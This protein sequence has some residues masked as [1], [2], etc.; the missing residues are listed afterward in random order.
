MPTPQSSL[1][2]FKEVKRRGLQGSLSTEKK[3]LYDEAER[4]GMLGDSPQDLDVPRSQIFWPTNQPQSVQGL[5]AR[6][7]RQQRRDNLNAMRPSAGEN[8]MGMADAG[9]TFMTGAAGQTAGGL[10]GLGRLVYEAYKGNPD[11]LNAAISGNGLSLENTSQFMTL[12]PSTEAGEDVLDFSSV[13]FEKI[14]EIAEGAGNK[15]LEITGSPFL[16]TATQVGIESLPISLQNIRSASQVAGRRTDVRAVEQEAK[17]VGIDLGADPVDRSNQIINAGDRQVSGQAEAGENIFPVAESATNL[18]NAQQAQVNNLYELARTRGDNTAVR[19]EAVIRVFSNADDALKADGFPLD[20]MPRVQGR[21]NA[22]NGIIDNAG[23]QVPLNELETWRKSVNR[24]IRRLGDDAEQQKALTELAKTYDG[25]MDDLFLTDMIIGDEFSISK[26]RNAREASREYFARW[27]SDRVMQKLREEDVT[28]R[29][30]KQM[31]L[32][33]NSINAPGPAVRTVNK[34]KEIFGEDSPEMRAIRSEMAF[35][36]VRPLFNDRPNFDAFI[37]NYDNL[38]K[39]NGRL[40]RDVFGEDALN[41]IEQIRRITGSIRENTSSGLGIDPTATAVRMLF[42]NTLS[43]NNARI[44]TAIALIKQ[45]GQ[46]A[47]S[48]SERQQIIS[49]V[50]GYDISKPLFSFTSNV[51]P[52]GVSQTATEENN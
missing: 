43:K 22:L 39:N 11:P 37:R 41:E 2:L 17:N 27:D 26:W 44:R 5:V 6:G 42:G 40:A 29:E 15:V 14:A 50:L 31:I 16:A 51:A 49:G 18:A 47:F 13:P 30:V 24:E 46:R 36:V 1:D 33:M 9:V 8:V 28:P 32:G 3:A 45:T 7:Q 20:T 34:L 21:M 4:R 23:G 19:D 38:I 48:G 25:V 10:A 52:L 12:S 35:D